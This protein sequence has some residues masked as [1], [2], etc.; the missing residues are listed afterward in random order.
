MQGAVRPEDSVSSPRPADSS[1]RRST[2]SLPRRQGNLDLSP[3]NVAV[4]AQCFGAPEE[5]STEC[6]L[7]NE[8]VPDPLAACRPTDFPIREAACGGEGGFAEQTRYQA[9]R[10]AYVAEADVD[11]LLSKTMVQHVCNLA[12]ANCAC[13]MRDSPAPPVQVGSL[14]DMEIRRAET[15]LRRSLLHR[16]NSVSNVDAL[17]SLSSECGEHSLESLL[18]APLLWSPPISPIPDDAGMVQTL[19]C[20]Y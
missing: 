19:W 10:F 15:R 11:L 4:G 5:I 6:A 18:P 13:V 20:K 16:Q 8:F 9:A 3:T 7:E 12:G 17:L 1:P 14:D 2:S